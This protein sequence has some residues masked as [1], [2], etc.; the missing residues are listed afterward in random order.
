[1]PLPL[2][3]EHATKFTNSVVIDNEINNESTIIRRCNNIGVQSVNQLSGMWEVDS[4]TVNDVGEVSRLGIC[5]WH[6][7]YDL[8]YLH[9]GIKDEQS[10]V[11][12][13]ITL[14]HCLLCKKIKCFFTRGSTCSL[15]TRNVCGRII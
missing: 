2:D 13:K 12:S 3:I 10:M 6:Y 4:Q 11:E 1:M 14:R 8:K 7:N 15:H 5:L 9:P